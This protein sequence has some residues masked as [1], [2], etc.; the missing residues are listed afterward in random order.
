MSIALNNGRRRYL[1]EEE[2]TFLQE[3]INENNGIEGARKK[4]KMTRWNTLADIFTRG[5]CSPGTYKTFNR[6]IFRKRVA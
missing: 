3:F 6:K 4:L 2:K 1:T 5:Y